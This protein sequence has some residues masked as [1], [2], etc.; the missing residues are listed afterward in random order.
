MRYLEKPLIVLVSIIGVVMFYKYF[1]DGT[2]YTRSNLDN[3]LYRV[4]SATGQ[5]EKADLLAL[6][7]LKLNVIVDS[8]KNANYNSNVSIQRLIKNWNKG[9]T[10]KEIGKMESDAAYVINKQYMSFCLPE[11]TSKT[12]DNT[13][14]MTY[15][16]IHELAH[17]MSNETGHGDE[18]IK[19][20]E[21][22]LNHAKTLNYTDPIMNKEVPVYIQLN[23]LNTAD[24][25]CGVPLVNSI[26]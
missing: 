17:I 18:F 4:R 6:M 26:N 21:F 11:N 14:L 12:L 10:I 24:N 25:Y 13:N 19:N 5:Q 23:K 15:V 2:E 7:N 3:K 16:G 1:Y 9:V 8:F 20:F 22:L